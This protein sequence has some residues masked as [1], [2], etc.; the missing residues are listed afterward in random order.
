MV[1][2]ASGCSPASTLKK[3]H[4]KVVIQYVTC[5]SAVLHVALIH[6]SRRRNAGHTSDCTLDIP[7]QHIL[8][9]SRIFVRSTFLQP[10][11][12]VSLPTQRQSHYNNFELGPD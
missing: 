7:T 11:Q 3:K 4:V 5:T 9:L 1:A 10:Y 8:S 2:L 12:F 6:N